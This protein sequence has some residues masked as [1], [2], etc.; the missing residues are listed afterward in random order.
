MKVVDLVKQ[1]FK[2]LEGPFLW[3]FLITCLF[4]YQTIHIALT[5]QGEPNNGLWVC[6]FFAG[7]STMITYFQGRKQHF[8][9]R[10][11]DAFVIG[12]DTEKVE[13]D[14]TVAFGMSHEDF[15][16]DGFTTEDGIVYQ[17]DD[18]IDIINGCAV[19]DQ[20]GKVTY[21]MT[22]TIEDWIE[23][24][25]YL[26][27]YQAVAL[28]VAGPL[29]GQYVDPYGGLPDLEKKILH[30]ITDK[31]HTD[32]MLAA[33]AIA[34]QHSMKFSKELMEQIQTSVTIGD[35]DGKEGEI[36]VLAKMAS[37]VGKLGQFM[38]FLN[39]IGYL[40]RIGITDYDYQTVWLCVESMDKRGMDYH[41]KMVAICLVNE[42]KDALIYDAVFLAEYNKYSRQWLGAAH[43]YFGIRLGMDN[44]GTSN[45]LLPDAIDKI[46]ALGGEESLVEVETIDSVL[47]TDEYAKN[48]QEKLK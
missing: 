31:L 43:Q 17:A 12:L 23:D 14:F 33:C 42:W 24:Q 45:D 40:K 39:G 13:S 4:Y 22:R 18:S 29:T 11:A 34:S 19:I 7:L 10:E 15:T 21:D 47:L 30:P 16:R 38:M 8:E 25:G 1:L 36:H 46:V 35:L 48:L 44:I 41:S 26:Y 2:P 37:D 20:D 9:N 27:T 32:D 28:C 6:A 5:R 3:S